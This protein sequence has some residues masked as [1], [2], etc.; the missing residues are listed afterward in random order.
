MCVSFSG[1]TEGSTLGWSLHACSSSERDTVG[2]GSAEVS[3]DAAAAVRYCFV[4]VKP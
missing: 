1:S 4:P 3:C 2:L